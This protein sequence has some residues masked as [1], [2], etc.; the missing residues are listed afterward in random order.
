MGVEIVHAGGVFAG[1]G[2]NGGDELAAI[3][4]DAEKIE[5]GAAKFHVAGFDA[6]EVER[7]I[8]GESLRI[9]AM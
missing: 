7:I 1:T 3:V 5:W 6:H 2:R 9:F 4:V 8:T